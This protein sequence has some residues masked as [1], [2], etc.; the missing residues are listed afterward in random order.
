MRTHDNESGIL[1]NLETNAH[2]RNVP[3]NHL[4][5]PDVVVEE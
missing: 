3:T 5:K 4:S 2:G 1:G